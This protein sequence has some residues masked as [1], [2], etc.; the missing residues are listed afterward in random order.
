M[1]GEQV[2]DKTD[3][4]KLLKGEAEPLDLV[5]VRE[6]LVE[7]FA[8]KIQRIRDEFSQNLQFDEGIELL[9]NEQMREFVYPVEQ[10]P[11]KIK[12][13][14]LD[15]TPTIRGV[16]QGIKGQYLILDTGV[17]NIRKYTGYEIIIRT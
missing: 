2:A 6:Q 9:E 4:R 16:L 8:P 11:E 17:I 5:E 12:S 10:Y 13:H 1:F 3:W 15:K 14:N 7:E